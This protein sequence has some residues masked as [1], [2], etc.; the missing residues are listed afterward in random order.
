MVVEVM[1][2]LPEVAIIFGGASRNGEN[3][4]QYGVIIEK[5]LSHSNLESASYDI[6]QIANANMANALS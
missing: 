3:W 6:Q 4:A 2:I 1:L 5:I